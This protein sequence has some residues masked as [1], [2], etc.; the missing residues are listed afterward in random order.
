MVLVRTCA[1]AGA[2]AS[3]SLKI[4]KGVAYAV[5]SRSTIE[6]FFAQGA[7]IGLH[8]KRGHVKN[9]PNP[10][11]YWDDIPDFLYSTVL[12]TSSS[13]SNFLPSLLGVTRSPLMASMLAPTHR[14]TKRSW[15][16]TLAATMNSRSS[17]TLTSR[18]IKR[19]IC[20]MIGA[21]T[22]YTLA[23][24]RMDGGSSTWTPGEAATTWNSY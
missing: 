19:R 11:G 15:N 16:S 17:V 8:R 14:Q 10:A 9:D 12:I 23:S 7:A 4:A 20:T 3:S 24:W 18:T 22:S 6:Q 1:D 5:G 13:S 21:T 2:I